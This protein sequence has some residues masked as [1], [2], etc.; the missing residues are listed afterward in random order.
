MLDEAALD[1]ASTKVSDEK[2]SDTAGA[3]AIGEIL[4]TRTY[5]LNI[6]YDKYYQ[7]PRLFLFGYNEQRKALSVD[8]MYEDFSADHANKTDFNNFNDGRWAKSEDKQWPSINS[9]FEPG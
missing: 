9:T 2:A 4:S 7:T 1:I 3:S 6:C 8:E 5:D